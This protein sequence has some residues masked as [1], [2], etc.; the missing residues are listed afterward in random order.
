MTSAMPAPER[1]WW[2]VVP[3]EGVPD[4]PGRGNDMRT[5]NAPGREAHGLCARADTADDDSALGLLNEAVSGFAGQGMALWEC[6]T[7]LLLSQRLARAGRLPEAAEEAGRAKALAVA[8]G[9]AWL[10]RAAIDQQRAIGGRRPRADAALTSALSARESEIVGM[11]RLGLPNRDI[12]DTLVISV[13][14]VEAHLTRIFR[15]TGVRSRTA[16]AAAAGGAARGWAG[17][18]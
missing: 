5:E 3:P 8:T 10:R 11:V 1:L 17:R 2:A 16:L 6:R 18:G 13:K 4:V 15:K 14:T 9:S 7:R 12:A